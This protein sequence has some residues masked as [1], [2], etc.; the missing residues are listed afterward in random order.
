MPVFNQHKIIFL[1]IG[2]TGGMS[3]ERSLG[4][5][6]KDYRIFDQEFVYGLRKGVMTQHARLDYI[7]QFLSEDQRQWFK[8]T[9]IRNPW[10]RMISAFY[11]L[12]PRHL[13]Q[14]GSFRKW[15][16]NKY[17]SLVSNSWGEGSHYTPQISYTH[18]DGVQVVDEILRTETLQDDFNQMCQRQK[19]EAKTL[20]RINRSRLREGK[21]LD[22]YDSITRDLVYE[23]YQD[24][25]IHF[26]F[27]YE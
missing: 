15:L 9:T 3:I 4:L 16:E 13:K 7:D 22:D 14:F 6:E 2:K 12:Q 24:E 25:I 10:H 8:F 17:E 1:H 5:P 20:T 26:G 11:Y 21:Y 19:I 27:R 23:M 18:K